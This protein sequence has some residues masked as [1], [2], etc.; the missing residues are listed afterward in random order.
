[1]Y[2]Y[3]YCLCR[4]HV[5]VHVHVDVLTDVV[6]GSSA[7]LPIELLSPQLLEVLDCEGPEVEDIVPGEGAP[8]LNDSHVTSQEK[9]VD[10]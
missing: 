10:G 6:N 3:M 2:M 1:M 5:H 4:I 8:L 9:T 7:E